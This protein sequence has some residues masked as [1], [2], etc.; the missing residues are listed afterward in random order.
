MNEPGN[1]SPENTNLNMETTEVCPHCEAEVIL[2]HNIS[3]GYK[4][5]CPECG[6]RLML[7]DLCQHRDGLPDENGY[8]ISQGDCDYNSQTDSCRFNPQRKKRAG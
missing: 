3:D 8:V 7:C 1:A 4:T 2:K 5:V 6:N